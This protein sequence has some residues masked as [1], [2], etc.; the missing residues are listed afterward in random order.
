MEKPMYPSPYI[1]ITQKDH[2][3]THADCW[4]VDE[5]GSDG[6]IDYLNAPFTGTIKKIYTADANEVWLESIEPVEYPDGTKDYMTMMSAHDND[7]SNLKVGQV[8]KQGQRFYEEGTK[9]NATGNHVHMEFAKG[10]FTGTGWHKDNAGYWS[11]NNGKKIDECLWIDDSYKLMNTAGYKFKNVKDA[12]PKKYGNPV[13]KDETRNQIQI[14]ADNV[15][16]RNNPNGDILGYMNPGIYNSLEFVTEAGYDWHR[17]SDGLWFA[18]GEWAT[19]LPKKEDAKVEEN[20][21]NEKQD[22]PV[23]EESPDESGL[24]EEKPDSAEELQT[25]AEQ[26]QK[27]LAEKEE[28]INNLSAGVT[29]LTNTIIDKNKEIS[30]LKEQLAIAPKLI[31]ESTKLD[32]Y[33]IKLGENQKL[34]LG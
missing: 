14:N 6:G 24:N 28:I 30:A 29:E 33:A 7:V 19:W 12:E 9:G 22:A 25:T 13:S 17:V 5:A 15:R 8:I 34:Y 1:R 2:V 10:K 23:Q 11:I 18:N 27:E 4:A 26:L 20:A 3:G 16:A 32:Y 31:F 21:S